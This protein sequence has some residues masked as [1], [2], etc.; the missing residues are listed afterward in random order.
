[1]AVIFQDNFTESA[2]TAVSAHT[3]SP[4]GTSW[5]EEVK[6]GTPI[7]TILAANDRAE[8]SANATSQRCTYSAQPNPSVS[9]YDVEVVLANYSSTSPRCGFIM[10]RF[11]SDADAG[12]GYVHIA[13]GD[14][15][16][17]RLVKRIS[18]T[19]TELATTD[20]GN[21]VGDTHKLEIRSASKKC[22]RN[23][24]EILSSS[25]DT[26]TATGKAGMGL[27]NQFNT[28]NINSH[29]YD[30]FKVTEV[31]SGT[32]HTKTGKGVLI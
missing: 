10:G 28:G 12:Y 32:T 13:S 8:Q 31:S 15:T 6:S 23:G 25:D 17:K 18:S 16:D 5:T 19:N 26:I 7:M 21:S 27:G 4:T 24:G 29:A 11:T 20:T 3:P 2:D 30:D 22:Y 14:T 1:M 9:E